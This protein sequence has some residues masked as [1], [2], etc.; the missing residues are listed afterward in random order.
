MASI[1]LPASTI[2][3]DLNAGEDRPPGADR[4]ADI[5]TKQEW[6]ARVLADVECQGLLVIDQANQRSSTGA[7]GWVGSATCWAVRKNGA[8]Q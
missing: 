6:M 3:L 2:E 1:A 5:D 7:G 8:C 4:R